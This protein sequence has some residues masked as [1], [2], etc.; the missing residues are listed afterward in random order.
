MEGGDADDSE[1]KGLAVIG[2][3]KRPY[4]VDD[5]CKLPRMR[6]LASH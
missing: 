5:V 2:N 1:D 6:K 3:F 4:Q